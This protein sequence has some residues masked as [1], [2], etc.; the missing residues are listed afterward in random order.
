VI[1][2]LI[3]KTSAIQIQEKLEEYPIYKAT[4]IIAV[5]KGRV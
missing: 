1:H 4:K 5:C 3:A 2:L